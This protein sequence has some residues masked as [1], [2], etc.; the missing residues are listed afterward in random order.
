MASSGEYGKEHYKKIMMKV[1][2]TWV[3]NSF[4]SVDELASA[5]GRSPKTLK[6]DYVTVLRK[7]GKILD[8]KKRT[9][10]ENQIEKHRTPTVLQQF[11]NLSPS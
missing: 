7:E 2:E 4:G 9:R 3:T 6:T 10:I 11:Q 5:I 8:G 1:V